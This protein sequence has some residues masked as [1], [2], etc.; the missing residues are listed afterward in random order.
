MG[1][2]FQRWFCGLHS[3]LRQPG[4]ACALPRWRPEVKVKMA[5]VNLQAPAI[6]HYKLGLSIFVAFE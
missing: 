4:L 2:T 1:K 6:R 5:D 3:V